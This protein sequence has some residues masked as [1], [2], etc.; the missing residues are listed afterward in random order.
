MSSSV[1]HNSLVMAIGTAAS[2]LT[3]Q[4]RTIL[5]AAAVGTTGMAANAYQAG[6]MIPQVIFSLISGG[7]FNAVLVPQIVRTLKEDD[8]ED[9]LNKLITFAIA[10]LAGITV[11]M[12]LLTATT[13]AFTH[14]YAN[15]G[16]DMLALTNA[17]ALWCMPQIFFYGLY[18]VLGQILAAKNHFGMYAWSSVA[19]NIV[20]CAGFTLF[21]VLF[22]KADKQ[23]LNFWTT[24][25]IMLTAGTWTLG[26]AVQAL[27]LF[28]PLFRL[29]VHY[30]WR[31]GVHGIGLRSMGSVAAWSLGI[32]GV[33]QLLTILSTRITTNAPLRAHQLFGIDETLVAGNATYQNAFTIYILPYSLIAVSV[34]TAVF[35]K[36]S[37][38]VADNDMQTARIDLSDAL[39]NV[40]LLMSYFTAVFVVMSVPISL[41]LLPS[42]SVGEA[43]L[44]S[45]PLI[46]LSLSLPLSS[47]YLIIQRTFYAFEDGRSPFIFMAVQLSIQMI[48]LLAVTYT[49][50][51]LHWTTM[52]GVAVTVAYATSFPLLVWMLRKRFENRLDGRRIAL[53]FIKASVATVAAIVVGLWLRTPVYHLV[54]ADLDGGR[55][56]MNWIQAV[57][58]CVILAVII[59]VMFV[60]ALWGMHTEEL[61]GLLSS[62][63]RRFS[64]HGAAPA[65]IPAA[66][67]ESKEPPVPSAEHPDA[68]AS[69]GNEHTV[70]AAAVSTT[71]V[72]RM[73]TTAPR[74]RDVLDM[75][76]KEHMKPQLGDT[77]INRYTLV[78]LLRDEPGL[79]AWKAN[80]RVLARDCQLFIVTDADAIPTVDAIASSLALS[81]N[82]RYTQ[83]LQLQHRAGVSIIITSVDNG[84][85]LTDYFRGPASKTL[86]QAAIR[87]ILGETASAM[88]QLLVDGL[89]HY[90]LSTDTIRL[91]VNGVQL[92]DAT[93]SP[94]LADTSRAPAGL[95]PERLAIRQLAAVL[96]ALITRTPSSVDAPID[97]NRLGPDVPGE[98]RL[99]CHRG[100]GSS[101]E[102]GVVPMESLAELTALLGNW[103]PLNQLHDSDI[104]LPSVDAECSIAS[105]ALRAPVPEHILDFP[106]DLASSFEQHAYAQAQAAQVGAIPA[107]PLPSKPTTDD[108][109]AKDIAERQQAMQQAMQQESAEWMKNSQ[110]A[111]RNPNRQ[112]PIPRPDPSDSSDYDFHDIAAAE[113][114]NIIAPSVPDPDNAIFPNFNV[115][116]DPYTDTQATMRFDFARKAAKNAHRLQ[117]PSTGESTSRIP[118]FDANGMPVEPGDESRRALE[119]EQTQILA[120]N[121]PISRPPSFTPTVEPEHEEH[122]AYNPVEQDDVADATLFGRFSTK[123]VAIVVVIVVVA[124]AAGLAWHSLSG[125]TTIGATKQSSAWPSENLDKVP[126]GSS[127]PTSDASGSSSSSGKSK[128]IN[129]DKDA[130]AVPTPTVPENNTPYTIDKQEFLTKPGG[131]DGY[132]YYMHLSEPESVYRFVVSIR[133]SGG[134]GYLYANTTADPTQGE[135]VAQ[136]AFD[137]SGKT[138][139]KLTKT[140]KSQDFLMWVPRDSLPGNQL[141]INS[142]ELY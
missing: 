26:V 45:G 8:A 130:S 85:S 19:A 100:L 95:S 21:I 70:A 54:G 104:A 109:Q 135:Q 12:M 114:A 34:A 141:Y 23:P 142:V 99:I 131:Q 119:D 97:L 87:S 49:M 116:T 127:T 56:H 65:E 75:E 44:M 129:A 126:F 68:P 16:K 66:G 106:P 14:L 32:V 35:P 101:N 9:R 72:S 43:Q 62:L 3:G 58:V 50:S 6:S 125:G 89:S 121:S 20:S 138:E 64:R 40:S 124:A 73:T 84:L 103:E 107:V 133:S 83:V 36:I 136:F 77:I 113:V 18:T 57:L 39:R 108:Q 55:P 30:R 29:G 111:P 81:R 33:D 82:R 17:F 37:R 96:Y 53:S 27:V 71:P 28:I 117:P 86:S 79:Q 120:A 110:A 10:L 94:M 52:R 51:P 2:R 118:V 76:P 67:S 123:V 22:G 41:A 98:F 11:A 31:W 137:A 78:S 92:A 128:V 91:T 60:G 61:L 90:S 46:A 69:D 47:A 42:I 93:I 122:D 13:P 24:D 102:P 38:A 139:V 134:T 80:D 63:K 115:P 15:G 4:I 112:P 132:G 88:R 1:G 7:I 105:A 140:V 48:I 74:S 5:L 25:K 59:T